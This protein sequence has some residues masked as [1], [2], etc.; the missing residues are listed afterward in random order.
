MTGKADMEGAGHGGADIARTGEAVA[1]ERG[2]NA[3]HPFMIG[4]RGWW[5]IVIRV[6]RANGE[7]N[8]SVSAAGVAFFTMLAIF[9]SLTAFV[10][11]YGLV[12]DPIDVQTHFVSLRSLIPT[13]AWILLNDQLSQITA[14]DRSDLGWGIV[15][16]L[17]LAVWSSG[18][19]VRALMSTLNVVYAEREKRNLLVFFGTGVLLTLGGLFAG[20]LSL[21]FI[22]GT[23]LVLK[24]FVLEE[25]I[26]IVLDVVVWFILAGVMVVGLAVLFRYGPSR[27]NAKIRWISVGSVLATVV[28]VLASLGF[29]FFVRNF[30]NYQETYG[31]LGAIVVL[32]MWFWV[33]AYVVLIGA[34]FNAQ[35]ELQ[36]TKDTT[37]GAPRPMG[38]RGAYVADHVAE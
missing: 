4:L 11:L 35:M 1:G 5:E 18:A 20:L 25:S 22:V 21:V 2:R 37:E 14:Q 13:D 36:T 9:P 6:W 3:S 10:M 24:L 33:T 29:S 16:S 7:E 17:A 26:E 15:L 38:K 23:P 31:A 27:R 19:G 8:L 28:W 34:E 12:A 30:G 32:L